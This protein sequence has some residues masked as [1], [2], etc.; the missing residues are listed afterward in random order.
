MTLRLLGTTALS[1]VLLSSCQSTGPADTADGPAPSASAAKLTAVTYDHASYAVPAGW[2]EDDQSNVTHVVGNSSPETWI[3]HQDGEKAI[4]QWWDL[5]PESASA[6]KDQ[7]RRAID[8]GL[9]AMKGIDSARLTSMRDTAGLGCVADGAL[10]GEPKTLEVGDGYAL[11]Y[12]YTCTSMSGPA[13]AIAITA[14]GWDSRKHNVT[15][16]ATESYWKAHA[17]EL[18]A[19][20]DSFRVIT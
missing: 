1:V 18:E 6:T 20:A 14:Y 15:V 16:A 8:A 7:V 19:A 12:E 5:A 9:Q 13:H 17:E 11:R 10:V 2:K 4:I 3:E